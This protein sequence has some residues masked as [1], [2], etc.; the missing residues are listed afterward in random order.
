M[1]RTVISIAL[2]S[3]FSLSAYANQGHEQSSQSE[4]SEQQGASAQQ[5]QG[6][7]DQTLVKQAQEKLSAAGK[8]VG[9]PDGQMGP[10]TQA[11]LKEFQQ[12]KGLQPSGQLDQETIAAL[13][14]DQSSSATGGTSSGE[15]SSGQSSSGQ[16][17]SDQGSSGQSS[18]GQS[19]SDQSSS[20]QS[21]SGE[22]SGSS[23]KY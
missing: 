14:L 16:S 2:A 18:S 11:A 13:D 21:S 7:Q 1:K 4:Q 20:G 10:K 5:S 8:D 17:S 23:S 6:A 19:S 12:E 3:A 9:T 15:S 22:S